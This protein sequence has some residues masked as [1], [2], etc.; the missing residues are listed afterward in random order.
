MLKKPEPEPQSYDPDSDKFLIYR[1]DGTTSYRCPSYWSLRMDDM[2]LHF[3]ILDASDRYIAVH[4][5][6]VGS[7][8][9]ELPDGTS[10]Y[11]RAK[12]RYRNIP[13]DDY[14]YNG[15][16]IDDFTIDRDIFIPKL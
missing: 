13:D 2:E 16:Y 3:A 15:L 5:A 9:V 1:G 7:A 11:P 12:G 10:I 14:C 6:N 4:F 8:A